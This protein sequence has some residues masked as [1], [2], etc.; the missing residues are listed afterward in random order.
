VSLTE[1]QVIPGALERARGKLGFKTAG[2]LYGNDDAF[3]QAGYN[4][5]KA[6]LE[7]LGIKTVATQTF[8]KPDRDYNAQLT[9]LLA[10]KPEVLVVS[11]LAENAAGIVTQ[12]RQLGWTG[13]IF[14]GNGFNSP[15]LIKNAGPAAEGVLVGTAWDRT[16]SDPANLKFLEVMKARGIDPD[17]FA[18]QAYTGVLVVA[19]AIKLAGKGGRDD[20]KA[21][22]AKVKGLA[23]PLGNFSF[24]EN[25][26]GD[27]APALQQVK[28]GKFQ[29]VK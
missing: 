9:S 10:L 23:T 22:F 3:T 6:A 29:I 18:A 27:H 12:A 13:P 25:R 15:A 5:M 14:G 17:Q 16:S 24:Q 4:V 11:A 2:V 26:D 28:D 21:G 1:A 19:E 7:K 20:I 8:A